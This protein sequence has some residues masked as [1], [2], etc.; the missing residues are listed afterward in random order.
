MLQSEIKF[1]PLEWS[2]AQP[3]NNT[4]HY[5]HVTAQTPLGRFLITW[6]GWKTFDCP[7]IEETPWGGGE[8]GGAYSDLEDAKQAA[9]KHYKKKFYHYSYST[10]ENNKCRLHSTLIVL[11]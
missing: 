8:W 1:K 9:E 4:I 10:K 6:K 2:D 7:T 3:P 11:T 5:N